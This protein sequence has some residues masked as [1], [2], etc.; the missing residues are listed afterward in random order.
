MGNPSKREVYE[1]DDFRLDAGHLMLYYKDEELTLAPKAVETLV[2]LVERRGQIVS[3][4]ELLD[5]VWPDTVVEESN[6]FLYLSVLRKTLG[7]QGNGKPWVETLRRRGYRFSGGVRLVPAANHDRT[8]GIKPVPLHIV[9][10]PPPDTDDT[11]DK[12]RQLPRPFKRWIFAAAAVITVVTALAFAYPYFVRPPI[13][14]IAV[15]PFA[16]ESGDGE[17]EYLSDGMTETLIGSLSKLPNLEVKALSS[18]V[19]Y[20]GKN[21]D[22][23]TVGKELNVNAVLYGKVVQRGDDLVLNVELVDPLTENSRWTHTYKRKVSNLVVLQEDLARDLVREISLKLSGSDEQKLAKRYT[24]NPEAY[25]L[26]LRGRN[27]TLKITPPEINEGIGYLQQAVEKDPSYALAHATIARARI[28][29]AVGG[30]EHPSELLKAKAAALTAIEIDDTVAEGHSA[31][32]YT[33]YFYDWKFAEA[34]NHFLRA[35]ELDPNSAAVHQGYGDL[36]GRMGRREEAA[37]HTSR[38]RELEPFSAFYNAFGSP[39]GNPD[40]AIERLR[41]AI[42][43]DPNNYFAHMMAAGAYRQKKMYAESVEEFRIA[44]RL[45]P[46]QTWSDAG[47]AATL[48][49]MDDWDGAR[50]ILDDML[51]KT[52]ERFVP[53][54]NIA[55]VHNLLGEKEKAMAMLEKGYEVRDPKMVFLKTDPRLKDLRED[56]RFQDLLR[57]VGF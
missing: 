18:V 34:E 14:S 25:Q 47:L 17:L 21:T 15:I 10:P 4:V 1:F 56:P 57:R 40:A 51:R 45:S 48:L 33:M 27:L 55:L 28:S 8:P 50:A 24:D 32:A 53:P 9:P 36:L 16:N 20:K 31:L 13:A 46:H 39:Q 38:S 26:F 42:D 7:T 11:A 29:L 52:K 49:A 41:F 35:L 3:K 5:A 2:A 6:L 23:P 22:A 30:E 12:L 44:K 19:R 54:F 43:L 37:A